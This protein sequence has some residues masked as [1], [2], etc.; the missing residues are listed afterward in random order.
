MWQL[1]EEDSYLDTEELII[2][3]VFNI[4]IREEAKCM[5]YERP[6]EIKMRKS[7][8]KIVGK[9]GREFIKKVERISKK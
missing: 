5:D 7:K 9:Y 6:K 2:A 4:R 1:I 3:G 8:G